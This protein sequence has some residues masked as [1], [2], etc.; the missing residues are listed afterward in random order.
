MG[1]LVEPL[2]VRVESCLESITSKKAEIAQNQ[3]DLKR[4]RGVSEKLNVELE[5]LQQNL[6][7]YQRALVAELART[8]TPIESD[9]EIILKAQDTEADGQPA[10]VRK[11][12]FLLEVIGKAKLGIRP[13][14][15][16]AAFKKAGL[17]TTPEYVYTMLA[18][19]KAKEKIREEDGKYFENSS[20]QE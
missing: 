3:E 6:S 9:F 2:K 17:Q 8:D 1:S 20:A 18:R 7:V 13:N 4:L 19:F 15:I 5:K 10:D 16:I 14:K 11:S 12:D